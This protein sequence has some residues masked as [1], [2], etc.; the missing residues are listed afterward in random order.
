MRTEPRLSVL[1]LVPYPL[2]TAPGQRYR[3]EQWAP[4]L[5][6]AGIDVHFEPFAATALSVALYRPGHY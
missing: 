3:I 5:R 2:D 6:D 4:Y 1:A